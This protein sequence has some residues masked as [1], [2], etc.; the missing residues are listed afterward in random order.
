MVVLLFIGGAA[1]AD[2]VLQ[3]FLPLAANPLTSY[4]SEL[5][6]DGQ[7]F[8]DVF[9][10]TDTVSGLLMIAGAAS[11]W[12]LAR[13]WWPVWTALLLLGASNV[14]E[15][16]S[17]MRCVITFAAACT[18][19]VKQ[20]LMAT[21]FNPHAW[22]SVMQTVSCFFVIIAGTVALRRSGAGRA[23]WWVLCVVAALTIFISVFEGGLTVELLAHSHDNILGLMQR[24]E[25][26][27]TGIWLAFAPPYLLFRARV[28]AWEAI[29]VRE[30]ELE[31][32][33]PRWKSASAA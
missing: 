33:Q 13:G 10:A 2:W 12:Y 20:S 3:L 19:P 18:P 7:P 17:P 6:A 14:L 30:P 32:S 28:R 9:R 31:A 15:A 11:A 16:M 21:V 25:V 8:A 27:F 22:V 24:V 1:Y 29:P 5:S 4:I 23:R 26:T